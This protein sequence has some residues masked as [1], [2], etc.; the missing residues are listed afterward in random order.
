[1]NENKHELIKKERNCEKQTNEKNTN[2]NQK[3]TN[4]NQ[5]NTNINQIFIG[6]GLWDGSRLTW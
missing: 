4:I 1:M 3:N 5:K 6:R 2:I